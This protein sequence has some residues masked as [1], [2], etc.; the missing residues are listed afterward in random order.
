MPNPNPVTYPPAVLTPSK[1]KGDPVAIGDLVFNAT[2]ASGVQW[3]LEAFDGWDSPGSTATL[4]QRS[5]GH[6]ATSCGMG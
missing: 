2:D 6:G 3:V 1:A 5:R 4:T